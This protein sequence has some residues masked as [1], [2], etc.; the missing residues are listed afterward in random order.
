MALVGDLLEPSVQDD[1]WH[2]TGGGLRLSIDERIEN[3]IG[4][5]RGVINHDAAIFLTCATG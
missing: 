5:P 1:G 4:L 3:S 2:G